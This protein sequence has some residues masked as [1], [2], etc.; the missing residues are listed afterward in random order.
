MLFPK[1]NKCSSTVFC[2]CSY[3]VLAGVFSNA[4]PVAS[5][6]TFTANFAAPIDLPLV[7]DKFGVAQVP[8]VTQEMIQ[9]ASPFLAE[10]GIRDIR[11]EMGIGQPTSLAYDQ[12]GGTATAPTYDFSSIDG[13]I[14]SWDAENTFP[15]LAFGYD[16]VP[17]QTD[18]SA[19]D[20]PSNLSTWGSINEA[21]ANHIRNSDGRPGVWFEEWNE[22]DLPNNSGGKFFFNGDE[23]DYGNVYLYGA[24]G[25][26]SGDPD[27]RVG[28]P[29]VAIDLTYLTQSGILNDPIDF[30]SIHG[31]PEYS[32]HLS[33]LRSAV[34]GTQPNLPARP[35]LPLL[36]TEF[37]PYTSFT[38][39]SPNSLHQAAASFFDNVS[40]LLTE[41]DNPKV[42]WS[43]W[44]DTVG[45]GMLTGDFHRKAL[46][47][48]FKIYQ[49]MLPADRK[50][51]TPALSNNVGSMAAGD[52]DNSG[53]VIWNNN[54]SVVNVTAIMN[55]IPF[56][57]GTARL[58]TIDQNHASYEDGAPENLTVDQQWAVNGGSTTWNGTIQA[59]SVVYIHVSDGTG[60]S[61]LAPKNIGKFVRSYYWYFKR[62]GKGTSY[63]DFDPLT[64]IAR[65]GMGVNDSDV[66][67][68]GNVYDNPVNQLTITVGRSGPFTQQDTNAEF[69]L[70]IDFQNTSGIYDK[71]VF[72]TNTGFYNSSRTAGFPWGKGGA[73]PDQVINQTGMTSGQ[74]FNI[75]L[76]NIAPADWNGTRVIITPIIQNMGNGSRSRIQIAPCQSN[77]S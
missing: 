18:G 16:P 24:N 21:Y 40:G 5:A 13:L 28:G 72:Y 74:P 71:S 36:L 68:I 55:N 2:F 8:H 53:L 11:Y 45:V 1:I 64:S 57:N 65:V 70:R 25:V 77:C 75:N 56:G 6:Q 22:P 58:Y 76:S 63:S 39:Q 31:Y 32:P 69:G 54:T 51:V 66:A 33:E 10:A 62:P 48:A 15:L 38:N 50:S 52:Q 12:V 27:A 26:N 59:Q 60:Q 3:T 7:K 17:L 46:F 49:T 42:Y 20:V 29:A 41:T 34:D 44:I 30:V 35:N 14:Q 67:L 43:A 23:T 37:A 61:L 9:D 19:K 4:V 73:R 47:N